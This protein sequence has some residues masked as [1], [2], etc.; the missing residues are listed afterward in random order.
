M[1]PFT[2]LIVVAALAG[3]SAQ[4]KIPPEQDYLFVLGDMAGAFQTALGEA[5]AG[6]LE[7]VLAAGQGVLLIRT[8]TAGT[9]T[10][11]PILSNIS[12]FEKELNAAG[13]QGFA[14][15][16]ST[17]TKAGGHP[18]VIMRRAPN[19]ADPRAYR[20]LER[21][22]AFESNMA[23]LV[24]KGFTTIGVFAH[25]SGMAAQLGRPGR[26]YAVLQAG[27]S[28]PVAASQFRVVSTIRT[29]TM[30]KEINEAA[31]EGYRVLGSALMNVLLIKG[32][33]ASA[34]YS[35]RLIGTSRGSTLAKEIQQAGQ[36]G[37]RLMPSTIMGNPSARAETVLLMERAVISKAY[38]YDFVDAKSQT[39]ALELATQKNN[40]LS[41]VAIMSPVA[42]GFGINGPYHI[43]VE[44]ER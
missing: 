26:L 24:S 12:S 32:G 19:E 42:V 36:D 38:D 37:Y 22:D 4:T 40:G 25:L 30:E 7:P 43:V 34:Q 31:A 35:Y 16:P 21:D 39:A 29:S 3:A 9:W 28:Q 27:V 14:A 33:E 15:L 20:V 6:G 18:F 17:L 2:F 44:K 23:A 5:A 11:Q 13:A 10:Y 1:R 41:P 8:A